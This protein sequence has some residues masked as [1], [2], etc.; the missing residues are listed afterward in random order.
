V[1]RFGKRTRVGT[2]VQ[3]WITEKPVVA[4]SEVEYLVIAGGGG[5]GAGTGSG[6]GAGGYRSSVVGE[7]SGGGASAESKLSVTVGTTYTVTVGGG[8]AKGTG[9]STSGNPGA[10]G[11]NSVFG[12]ITSSGGGGGVRNE[13]T[14]LAGGSGSGAGASNSTTKAGGAGTA[15]E[16]YAGGASPVGGRLPQAVVVVRQR[17]DSHPI[18]I[19]MVGRAERA[20]RRQLLGRQSVERAVVVAVSYQL[21][22]VALQ[23]MVERLVFGLVPL[24]TPTPT[25]VAV[26]AAVAQT[27]PITDRM[28]GRVL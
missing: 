14:G 7:S 16:G 18:T 27:V 8:G 13:L 11:S 23:P 4:P 22:T 25:K 15:N 20:Y 10:S 24:L 26:E 5:G 6:A 21:V 9:N 3:T 19:V 17:L 28:V 2:Q 1:S 12:S